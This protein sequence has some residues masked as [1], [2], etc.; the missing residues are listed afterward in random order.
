MVVANARG[1]NNGQPFVEVDAPVMPGATTF[2]DAIRI[3]NPTPYAPNPLIRVEVVENITEQNEPAGTLQA[4]NRGLFLNNGTFLVEFNSTANKTYFIQYSS[5]LVN[6]T[7]VF[8][9]IKGNGAKILWIDSGPPSTESFPS[10]NQ[11]RYYRV[12]VAQ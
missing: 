11:A 4:I 5:N 1:T 9:G 8:P 6:W 7:T 3:Y 2:T 12:L 10:I